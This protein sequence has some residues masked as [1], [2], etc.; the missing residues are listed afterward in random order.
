M[1]QSQI[2][3]SI[4]CPQCRGEVKAED[5]K[6]SCL[7]CQLVFKI[8]DGIPVFLIENAQNHSNT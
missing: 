7:V 1:D 4:V 6:I 3:E 8:K 2:D 5:L